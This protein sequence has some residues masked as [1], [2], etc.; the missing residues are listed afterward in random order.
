MNICREELPGAFPCT[1]PS[2]GQCCCCCGVVVTCP[3]TMDLSRWSTACLA[4]AGRSGCSMSAT[5][6]HTASTACCQQKQNKN[7]SKGMRQESSAPPGISW[8]Q[9]T[10]SYGNPWWRCRGFMSAVLCS[11]GHSPTWSCTQDK[12]SRHQIQPYTPGT[13]IPHSTLTSSGNICA[14]ASTQL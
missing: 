7:H 4:S 2:L 8:Q 10:V 12:P 11:E 3:W 9:L 14:K 5:T 6:F 13:G 1:K